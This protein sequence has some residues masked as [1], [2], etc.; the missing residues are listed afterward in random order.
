MLLTFTRRPATPLGLFDEND[1]YSKRWW[2]RAQ[3][4]ADVFWK[5]WLV[6][7]VPTLQPRSK[8]TREQPSLKKDDIVLVADENSSRC[9]W[10]L[11]RIMEVNKKRR[12]LH[13]ISSCSFSWKRTY[14]SHFSTLCSR[15]TPLMWFV[16]FVFVYFF[17][18]SLFFKCLSWYI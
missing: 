6:E 17:F 5:R 10:P 7:Y 14:S 8:W 3:H 4:I 15:A 12:W 2:R 18:H 11:G 1:V 9:D 13:S 16:W